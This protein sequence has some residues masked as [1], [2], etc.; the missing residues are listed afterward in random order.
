M[1]L[2]KCF[3]RTIIALQDFAVF[4]HKEATS[5]NLII[6]FFFLHQQKGACKVMT[7]KGVSLSSLWAS[8][9]WSRCSVDFV[10]RMSDRVMRAQLAPQSP[11]H[12]QASFEA[13]L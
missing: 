12:P 7:W 6:D 1:F 13:V 3:N 4:C 9:L 5:N 2:K 8:S 10:V 11:V